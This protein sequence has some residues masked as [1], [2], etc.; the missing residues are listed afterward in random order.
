MVDIPFWRHKD[1]ADMTDSEWESL[2]DRCGRCCL[3]K[4]EDEDSGEIAYTDVSCRLFDAGACTCSDYQNRQAKVADCVRLT[5]ETVAEIGW[6]PPTCAYRLVH[7]GRDLHWWH[8]LISGDP[9]T[10]HT[11]GIS[12]KGRISG[13]EG[14]FG[15]FELLDRIV[16]W[17]LSWPH[18]ARGRR[19]AP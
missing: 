1:L 7:E 18:G 6:L 9:E 10:V 12:V 14:A 13:P 5:P 8:P 3:V 17:P 16:S 2:C 11:A 15:V 4:L 19:R